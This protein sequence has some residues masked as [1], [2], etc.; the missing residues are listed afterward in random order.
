MNYFKYL[1]A[2]VMTLIIPSV[3][4]A[5]VFTEF[6][7]TGTA[8]LSDGTVVQLP[9]YLFDYD[10]AALVGTA[11]LTAL[12]S[13][14]QG[15][16]ILPLADVNGVGV[17]TVAIYGLHYRS[18]DLG[19][20]EEVIVSVAVQPKDQTN[21]RLT[22]YVPYISVTAHLPLLYGIDLLGLPKTLEKITYSTSNSDMNFV[23]NDLN[24]QSILSMNC[25]GCNT[26]P[27][28]SNRLDF[29]VASPL[30]SNGQRIWS[31]II[32]D[33]QGVEKP[34]VPA[35]GDSFAFNPASTIGAYLQ[36]IQFT[37]ASWIVGRQ[38]KAVD[39]IYP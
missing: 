1:F 4:K 8:T 17:G 3:S 18:T 21:P 13:T 2:I 24:N 9:L 26:L 35:L 11:N 23:F 15:Q 28:A 37:P 29:D 20:Y 38:I 33:N 5:D 36:Y 19:A 22:F 12:A 7:R 39:V 25:S 31:R 6:P 27:L 10:N 16:G 14:M 34:Y 32:A 30:Q